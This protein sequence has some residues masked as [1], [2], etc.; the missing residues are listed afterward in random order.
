EEI[1][2][3]LYDFLKKNQSISKF[4]II[5]YVD[6]LYIF[7]DTDINMEEVYEQII[8]FMNDVVYEYSITINI[9]KTGIKNVEELERDL[10]HLSYLDEE[11]IKGNID[12]IINDTDLYD[13]LFD[14]LIESN[15]TREKYNL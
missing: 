3:K 4:K 13:V 14:I 8:N 5:R 7:F 9:N 10:K 15:I 2:N 12:T 1:D 11:Y 6:D